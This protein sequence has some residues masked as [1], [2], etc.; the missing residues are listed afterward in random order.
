MRVEVRAERAERPLAGQ[1]QVG[2]LRLEEQRDVLAQ[3]LMP[4]AGEAHEPRRVG[5]A[6]PRARIEPPVPELLHDERKVGE[7]RPVV[8]RST[9]R[10]PPRHIQTGWLRTSAADQLLPGGLAER[11]IGMLLQALAADGSHLRARRSRRPPRRAPSR[12]SACPASTACDAG[13]RRASWP[14]ASRSR[15]TRCACRGR[16]RACFFSC[17]DFILM[18]NQST[19][20]PRRRF[21]RYRSNGVW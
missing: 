11:R 17:G 13:V 9:L 5:L 14:A 10:E 20:R 1:R 7:R 18:R 21:R 3:P 2:T 12:P 16:I 8:H 4:G 6:E 19:P 15:W